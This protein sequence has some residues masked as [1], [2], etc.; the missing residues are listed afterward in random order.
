MLN[1]NLPS[2]EWIHIDLDETDSTMLYLRRPD[3]LEHPAP[4]VL[5]TADF[6]TAG[7]G[8][9]GTS[10]EADAA[11]NLLFGIALRPVFLKPDR[12]F[13]LSEITALAIAEALD[14]YVEGVSIKWP[15]D[16]V[17][18][19]HKGAAKAPNPVSLFQL[20]HHTVS[21]EEVMERFLQRFADYYA[22]LEGGGATDEIHRTYHERLYRRDGRLHRFRDAGGK[23]LARLDGV[24]PDGH[25]LLTDETGHGRRYAFKEIQ[26]VLCS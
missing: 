18:L 8:Q 24:E 9:R 11:D 5:V 3:M 22:R 20:L 1:L 10:W 16:I 2:R 25:L 21:R 14:T 26:Y 17:A 12:Q 15:N 23:F 7:R 4:F 13:L 19:T 6:Q